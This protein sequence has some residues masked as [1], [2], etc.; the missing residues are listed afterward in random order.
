MDLQDEFVRLRR[1]LRKTM[2]LVTHD[3]REA[4]KLADRIAVMR[5]G[6]IL[7]AD[8][9]RVLLDDP[10]DDYVRDLLAHLHEEGSS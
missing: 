4:M 8:T 6:R 9:P 10:A 5:Q 2:L 1:Q 3:L 7:Q